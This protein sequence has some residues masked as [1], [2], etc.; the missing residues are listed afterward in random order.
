M[1]EIEFTLY[2]SILIKFLPRIDFS[3]KILIEVI[4]ASKD[5]IFFI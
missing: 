1:K 5:V 3:K 2:F 4:F